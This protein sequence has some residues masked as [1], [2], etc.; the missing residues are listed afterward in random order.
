VTVA[1]LQAV[2]GGRQDCS[3]FELAFSD[4]GKG[5]VRMALDQAAAVVPFERVAPVRSFPVYRGQRNYP[6]FYYAACLDAHVEFESWLERDEAMA[7]DFDPDVVAFAAQPFW[8]F[9]PDTDRVRS[10]APDFFARHRDGTGVVVDCRPAG[11]IKDRDAAAFAAT[12]RACGEVG[13]EY[14]LTT[15]HD[16]IWL[17]NVRWLA[18]YRHRRCHS[19]PVVERLLDAFTTIRPL[20]DGAEAVGEPIA[21]LPTLYHLLWSGRLR[22]DLSVR[23]DAMSLVS[24]VAG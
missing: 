2:R 10:H 9:W 18:G 12:E 3:E 22:A 16:P 24:T 20:I 11:R 23:L 6:G 19:Q 1:A 13:W 17:A 21:V 7:M 8:M 4:E 14:R 15:G 5:E